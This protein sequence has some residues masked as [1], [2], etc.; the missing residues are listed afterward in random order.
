MIKTGR[1]NIRIG[2]FNIY[3]V[4]Q[5]EDSLLFFALFKIFIRQLDL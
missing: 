4:K 5:S 3:K 2:K 1:L